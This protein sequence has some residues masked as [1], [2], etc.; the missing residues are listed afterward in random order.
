[1]TLGAAAVAA[2]TP[3]DVAVG[4]LVRAD[5]SFLLG[6]RPAGKPYSGYWEFPGGKVEPEESVAA[7]LERELHEELGIRIGASFG[8]VTREFDYPH[9]FVRLHFRRIFD[10]SGDLH[11]RE[12]QQFGFFTTGCLP[13][14][15]L[16]PAT[17][18]VLRWLRLPPVYRLSNARTLGSEAFLRRLDAQLANGARLVQLREPGLDDD[19]VG[20]L[21][22][23]ALARTRAH[24]ALLLVS[25][26]HPRALWDR[27][28]G[29]HL[30]A[31]HLRS[32]NTRPDVDWVG[33][34]CHSREE[35]ALAGRL[36][37]DLA[38]VGTVLPTPSHPDGLCIGW[39]G[40]E[41]QVVD[42]PVPAYAIGG[43]R[44]A[45]LSEAIARGAH[46]VALLSGAW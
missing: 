40:L 7:A 9:A 44:Q 19:Q 17:V 29:V 26:R 22:R 39:D 30:T 32:A 46:G 4:V 37:C 16:L 3:V 43:M 12:G 24:G 11:S 20:E 42:T 15:P 13:A 21:L 31:A 25:S 28:D 10:W 23:E 36:G 45:S 8:W 6:S 33:A 27:A 2:R 35:L 34:S 1:V 41:R 18:P 38:A 5:G 14:G